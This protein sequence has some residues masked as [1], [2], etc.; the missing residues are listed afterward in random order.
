M[1]PAVNRSRGRPKSKIANTDE[2]EPAEKRP[3]GRPKK[4][5]G[6]APVVKPAATR[7]RGR[8]KKEVGNNN[9]EQAGQK[10]AAAPRDDPLEESSPKKAK[11]ASC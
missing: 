3:R 1:E 7:P 4:A 11:T 6:D 2:I 5:V 8:P 10:A 9:K